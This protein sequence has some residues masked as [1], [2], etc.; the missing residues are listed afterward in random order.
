MEP[1]RLHV[2]TDADVGQRTPVL[3]LPRSRLEMVPGAGHP[4]V[5]QQPGAVVAA[6]QRFFADLP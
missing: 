4:I 1:I 2:D 3:I 5:V 6:L